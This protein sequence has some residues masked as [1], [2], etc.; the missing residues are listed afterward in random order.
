MPIRATYTEHEK[1]GRKLVIETEL[2]EAAF[3]KDRTPIWIA[4]AIANTRKALDKRGISV[5]IPEALADIY[6]E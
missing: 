5:P 3:D 4:D 1:H 6:D 2:S